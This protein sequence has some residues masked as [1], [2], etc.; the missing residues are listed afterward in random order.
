MRQPKGI[1]IVVAMIVISIL[2]VIG[3]LIFTRTV[4]D[5]RSSRDNGAIAQAVTLARGGAVAAGAFLSNNVRASLESIVRSPSAATG[6]ASTTNLWAYGGN[7]SQ[8]DRGLVATNLKVVASALQTQ[9]NS[10]ICL[11]NYAPD[12]SSATVTVRVFFT[13]NAS[14]GTAFPSS[15]SLSDG[16]IQDD[17]N[18]ESTPL[19]PSNQVYALP[20]VMVVTASPGNDYQRNVVIQGELR[21]TVGNQ[22]FARFA[23]FT[24]QHRTSSNAKVFFTDKTLF[25]GPVHTNESFYFAFDPWFGGYVTSAGCTNAGVSSCS[26]TTTAGAYFGPR[27]T[28]FKTPTQMINP[29]APSIAAGGVINA[30][31]FD[32]N[33]KVNWSEGFIPMPVN[34][35]DQQ[36]AASSSGLYI[37]SSAYSVKLFAGDS[38]GNSPTCNTSGVCTPNASPYQYIRVCTTSSSCS[39]YRY[40]SEDGPLYKQNTNGSWPSSP[41]VSRFNGMIYA[42][43]SINSLSGPTRSSSFPNDPK[44]APPALA[45]FAKI[46]VAN[47][48]AGNNIQIKG[49]LKYENSPC[50]GFP[51]RNPDGTVSRPSCNN[52]SAENVLGVY[53]QDGNIMLGDGTDNSLQNLTVN[54]VLMTSRGQVTVN[55]YSS[56]TPRGNINLLGGIIEYNYGAFG[57]FDSSSGNPISGYGRQFTYDQRML[58]PGSAPPFFPTTGVYAVSTATPLSFGQREQ[59]Y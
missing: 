55:N 45:S 16:S 24:N 19:N 59:V 53:S 27:N 13:K 26:G 5:L 56:I 6:G 17:D 37:S 50:T 10:S 42:N 35:Q 15:L 58:N 43:G 49:D 11:A 41:L 4:G 48:G 14:C 18:N 21:F 1:A 2:T 22:S 46:T 33:P 23:L 29:T 34:N 12:G 40:S 36:T 38:S 39:L 32:G 8:P 20:Y 44:T 9:I 28:V 3:G 54:G 31:K 30:P 25:D 47:A 7:N 52:L 51:T 57:Q